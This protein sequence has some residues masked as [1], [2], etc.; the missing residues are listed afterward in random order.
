MNDGTRRNKPNKTVIVG[1]IIALQAACTAF[2]VFDVSHDFLYEREETV[3]VLF[4]ALANV[5][6]VAGMIFGAIY[7]RRLLRQQAEAERAISVATGALRDVIEG[8][9]ADWKL[10]PSEADVARFTIKGFSIAEI[11]SLRGSAEGT[12]KTHL[13]SIYK[14]AG[15]TGR[16]QLVNL[17]IEDLMEGPILPPKETRAAE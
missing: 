2:F 7:L 17:L 1:L 10:T 5:G 6:L 13:N 14:K 11:A 12:I 4:E 15:V 16:A 8:Y 9:F 3:H